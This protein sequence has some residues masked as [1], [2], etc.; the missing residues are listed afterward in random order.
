[1][2]RPAI[3]ITGMRFGKLVVIRRNGL[4]RAGRNA[5]WLCKCDCGAETVVGS[6][7]LRSGTT[8]SCGCLMFE[9]KG[10]AFRMVGNTVYVQLS[11]ADAEMCCDATDWEALSQYTWALGAVGYAVTNSIN[12]RKPT[13]FHHLVIE[14]PYGLVRDHINRNKLDN[15]RCNLRVVTRREN[16]MNSD[17]FDKGG[18]GYLRGIKT[19]TN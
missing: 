3:D 14:C 15:R 2:G 4:G 8:K 6:R 1:M 16:I 13:S 18:W 19:A 11:N 10:N 17:S 5:H 9:R 7:D 12:R